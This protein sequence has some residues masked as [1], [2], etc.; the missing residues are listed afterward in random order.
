MVNYTYYGKKSLNDGRVYKKL[1]NTIFRMHWA[2]PQK[3]KAFKGENCQFEKVGAKDIIIDVD[4]EDNVNNALAITI[5]TV[6]YLT[7]KF[8]VKCNVWYSGKKGFHISIPFKEC[9]ELATYDVDKKSRIVGAYKELLDELEKSIDNAKYDATLQE[10][11]RPI[12]QPNKIKDKKEKGRGYKICIGENTNIEKDLEKIKKHSKENKDIIEPIQDIADEQDKFIEH[13]KTLENRYDAWS[14]L[15]FEVSVEDVDKE[16]NYTLD[17]EQLKEYTT[18]AL[19]NKVHSIHKE[20]HDIIGLIGWCCIDY[21]NKEQAKVILKQLQDNPTVNGT[22]N[23]ENS[24]WDAY[25]TGSN[26]LGALYKKLELD[27]DIK[28][29]AEKKTRWKLFKDFKTYLKT[30]KRKNENKKIT[31]NYNA[32]NLLLDEYDNDIVNLFDEEL[33]NYRNNSKVLFDGIIYSLATALGLDGQFLD[34]NAPAGEGKTTFK[35]VLFSLITNGE[36]IGSITKAVFY[37]LDADYFNRKV[38]YLNDTGLESSEEKEISLEVKRKIRELVTDKKSKRMIADKKDETGIVKLYKEVDA[39]SLINTELYSEKKQFKLGSQISS[40][41]ET[42]DIEPLS[43]DD[44][45][46]V[47]YDMQFPENKKKVENFKQMHRGYYQALIN[48]YKDSILEMNIYDKITNENNQTRTNQRIIAYYKSYCCYFGLNPNEVENT[49]KF[50][51]FYVTSTLNKIETDVFNEISKFMQPVDISKVSSYSDYQLNRIPK[52]KNLSY[53]NSFDNPIYFF[54]VDNIKSYI[55]AFRKER[56]L[57]EYKDNLS[58]ILAQ[59]EKYGELN[60]IYQHGEK[61][62][63]YIPKEE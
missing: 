56:R 27:A 16:S 18:T 5:T 20:R 34:L 43:Y 14:K 11:T 26:G 57:S 32:F 49:T 15:E 10:V 8:N 47:D 6:E 37:R 35:D 60:A 54:S 44:W 59:L 38:V 31:D 7:E 62:L 48:N 52:K 17:K 53:I 63:Y 61:K 24:F 39:T 29:D 55:Q 50:K 22:S 25:T 30:Y 58:E 42:L 33:I 28:D 51:E 9:I 46:K 12:Q 13:L 40:V 36:E 1:S 45:K 2:Y 23:L 41:T 19:V 4:D 3:P 21:L